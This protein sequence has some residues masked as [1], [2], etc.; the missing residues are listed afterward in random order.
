[1][2]EYEVALVRTFLVRIQAKNTE[3]AK[4]FSEFYL[5]YIDES[6]ESDRESNGFQIQEINMVQNDAIEVSP[7]NLDEMELYNKSAGETI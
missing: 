4:R 5:G 1:M 2:P 7:T 3:N 6:G